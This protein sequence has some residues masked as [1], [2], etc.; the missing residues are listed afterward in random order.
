MDGMDGWDGWDGWMG[1]MGWMGWRYI[2]GSFSRPFPG[3]FRAIFGPLKLFFERGEQRNLEK[4][5]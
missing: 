5:R 1:W 3:H 4:N 2:E